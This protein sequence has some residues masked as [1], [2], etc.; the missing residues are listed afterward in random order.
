MQFL[1]PNLSFDEINQ[2]NKGLIET[3]ELRFSAQ[4]LEKALVS[5]EGAGSDM[6]DLATLTGGRSIT[7]E[8]IDT[9]LKVTAE[10]R[11]QLVIY[12]LLRKKPI[13][14][15]L[16]QWM[17]LSD[18]GTNVQFGH[19]FGK[20]RSETA[21]PVVSD[22]TLERKV[23]ATKFIRDMRDLSHV[24]ETSK[25]YAEKHQI[26]N[27]AAAITVLEG[28]ELATIFGSSAMMPTQF[29][30]LYTQ[31][32]AAYNAGFTDAIVDCRATGSQSYSKGGD[33]TENL[34]EVG[35]ERILTN[36][37][38][39]THMLMPTKVK[40]DL[41]KILPV[42]RRVNL[43]GAQQAGARD[44]LLGQP[45]SGYY[46][47]FAYNGWGKGAD[48][49]FK[50]APSIDTFYPSG[51]SS[52]ATAPTADFPNTDDAP[53]EPTNVAGA[54]A[55]DASSKFAT[56][57]A[58][59]YYYKVSSVDADGQSLSVA[60][61]A[62][63]TVA[64]GEKCTLTITCNDAT[65]TG[66][67]I[68]RSVLGATNADDC[69]WIADIKSDDP[70]G[71]GNTFVDL[72]LILPGTSTALLLSNAEETD[73]IDYRQLMPFVRMEL[74]FGLNNIVGWPYLYM[75]Y[76]YLRIQKLRNA[77]VGGTYHILYINMRWS[78]SEYNPV[79]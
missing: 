8:N 62:A 51:E 46:S 78:E 30:G 75:L 20:W 14:A 15:V 50:F 58:G 44:L 13:Y 38:I 77:R 76:M 66:L 33:I 54:T 10:T 61:G 12:N 28:I 56:G 2:L 42:S 70:T 29:D 24:M 71:A 74:A 64:A 60:T 11:S 59:D 23:D 45:A 57:D 34:L 21:F 43:P 39:A 31:I 63:I 67:R 48:P 4:G 52:G 73:A 37:G 19:S 35:A 65:I 27:N 6:T 49:H 68:Y 9:E 22:V 79:V 7:V 26:I 25:T 53:A 16:D 17:Q 1:N 5:G 41:N 55:S 69:R 36:D 32:L 40:S 3:G 72:N 47:D 18:H